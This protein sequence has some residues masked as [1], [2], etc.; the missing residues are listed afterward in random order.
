ME[1]Q[2]LILKDGPVIENGSAGL[3]DGFLWLWFAGYSLG[4]AAMI[5][6]DP[7]KTSRIIF[8]YGEDEDVYNGFTNCVSL[9]IDSDGRISVCMTKG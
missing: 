3:A 4:E 6:F 8:Q 1:G 2:R 5:V 7:S 9:S